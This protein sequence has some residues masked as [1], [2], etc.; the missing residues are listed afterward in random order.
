MVVL[1]RTPNTAAQT[2][3]GVLTLPLPA[4][5][6]VRT[7]RIWHPTTEL[8]AVWTAEDCPEVRSWASREVVTVALSSARRRCDIPARVLRRLP[9]TSLPDLP[10]SA[11]GLQRLPRST[12]YEWVHEAGRV[13]RRDVRYARYASAG[14]TP[15]T[16]LA[17]A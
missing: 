5:P 13:R 14:R 2:I 3:F 10:N 17:A 6:L 15:L 1:P 8:P 4:W 12:G 7:W 9:R 11:N 16:T